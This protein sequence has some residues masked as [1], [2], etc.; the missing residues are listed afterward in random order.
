MIRPVFLMAALLYC[1][2]VGKCGEQPSSKEIAVVDAPSPTDKRDIP[3][4]V[5]VDPGQPY[6]IHGRTNI[7]SASRADW[8][9]GMC[10]ALL[11]SGESL[12]KAC[13]LEGE[14]LHVGSG[15]SISAVDDG[16]YDVTFD[17][18]SPPMKINMKPYSG[19]EDADHP[20]WISGSAKWP[21]TDHVY[22]VYIYFH[23]FD[24][25][26]YHIEFFAKPC[27]SHRP[28]WDHLSSS[29]TCN[30]EEKDRSRQFPVSDGQPR[31]MVG[32]VCKSQ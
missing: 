5:L 19:L 1:G 24:H 9:T 3:P 7:V 11:V 10:T 25:K 29:G 23:N 6:C 17:S 13:Q 26:L 2:A 32:G 31:T 14:D 16:T 30:T 8:A 27:Y 28:D 21:G 12:D 20:I 4:P 18:M 15:V 22:F